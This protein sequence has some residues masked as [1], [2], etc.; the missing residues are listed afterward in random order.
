VLEEAL[1]LKLNEAWGLTDS[2]GCEISPSFMGE[3]E[4]DDDFSGRLST[5][6]SALS[7]ASDE[8]QL[9][10][11]IARARVV[12]GVVGLVTFLLAIAPLEEVERLT[13]R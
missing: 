13:K 10:L 8:E 2:D 1:L 5:S 4:S 12:V 7:S 6:F 3:C 11:K 9:R